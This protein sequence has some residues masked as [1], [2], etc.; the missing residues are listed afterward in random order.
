MQVQKKREKMAL[1]PNLMRDANS[2][3][4]KHIRGY[5]EYR[6]YFEKVVRDLYRKKHYHDSS[7]LFFLRLY[8]ALA[9]LEEGNHIFR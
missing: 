4:F 6:K 9:P 1:F 5:K 7:I 3:A 2:K 8:C